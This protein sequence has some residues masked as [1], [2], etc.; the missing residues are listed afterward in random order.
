MPEF[1]LTSPDLV[2]CAGSPDIPVDNYCDSPEFLDV[3]CCKPMESS[4]ELS[5]EN[6]F[7]G[8]EVNYNQRTPTVRFSK[9]CETY[10]QELS[11]E[12]S[13]ELAPPPATSSLQSEELVQSVSVNAGSSRDA[14][15]FD[16]INYVEDNWYKGGDTIR[17]DEIEHPLYQTARFGNFCYN[18]SSLEPG[19]Y[20]VDL[21]FAE[22]VF[23][24]GP[25][26]MR[27]FDV[28]LQDQKVRTYISFPNHP[29]NIIL[30]FCSQS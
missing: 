15:T 30:N 8:I 16:G 12:S 27:V 29:H 7:S 6:S 21:H 4:M 2:V 22:I 28:Y 10:E 20:V 9:L 5:F 3:K 26:G 11:P 23:T 13:F 24:N 25:P 1:T 14:V 17:S 19:N 18:F